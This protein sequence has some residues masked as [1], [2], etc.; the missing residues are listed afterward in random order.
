MLSKTL[1][2][3]RNLRM[4]ERNLKNNNFVLSDLRE[5]NVISTPAVHSESLAA[6]D[7]DVLIELNMTDLLHVRGGFRSE[8]AAYGVVTLISDTGGQL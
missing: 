1:K 2:H 8:S 5:S 6:T 3:S 7:T 4:K